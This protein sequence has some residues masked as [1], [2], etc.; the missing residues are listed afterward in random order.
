MIRAENC[1]IISPSEFASSVESG[2]VLEMSIVLR[3]RA[4]LEDNEEMC[5]RCNHVN[6]NV[7]SNSGWIEWQVLKVS[8]NT[9][10]Y[11]ICYSRKCSGQ[12]QVAKEKDIKYAAMGALGDSKA[13]GGKQGD[14]DS[15][16]EVISPAS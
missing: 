5:P 8:T 13:A 15:D 12:F 3:K 11:I 16:Q 10:I 1:Q 7:T 4:T 9:E 6:L 14:E 2:M